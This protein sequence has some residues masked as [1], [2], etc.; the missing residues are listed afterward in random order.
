MLLGFGYS[1]NLRALFL[2]P[3]EGGIKIDT[4]QDVI[5]HIDKVFL[6][7]TE[8]QDATSKESLEG[9]DDIR[10][11]KTNLKINHPSFKGK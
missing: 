10:H 9:Y 3:G 7:C 4:D 11:K 5:D 1:C 8:F 2:L 6:P